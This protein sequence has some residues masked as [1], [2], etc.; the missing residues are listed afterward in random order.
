MSDVSTWLAHEW[1]DRLGPA[2][3]AMSGT[4]AQAKWDDAQPPLEGD[5]AL[6][7]RQ[8]VDFSP[9]TSI[10]VAFG[11]EVWFAI[12]KRVLES[13]GL[14][15]ADESDVRGTFIEVLQQSLS[16]LT[17]P[18]G[19][20]VEH[21]VSMSG[22]EASDALPDG[23]EWRAVEVSM[24]NGTLGRAWLAVTRPMEEALAIRERA[25]AAQVGASAEATALPRGSRTL[26]L[27]MEVELPVGVSFGRAQMRLKDAIKLTT[28]SIVEL[29]R[30]IVEPVEIVVN[31]CVIARGEV[32]VVQ[33]NYGVR[34]QQ[35]ISREERLRTLF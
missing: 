1:A 17:S 32:V 30:S 7:W 20:R 11:R 29:N 33:G 34:I 22:G 3:S 27:L 5:G 16:Q 24:D 6:L 26:D 21:E 19:A 31:N 14:E 9:E 28:G 15:D 8:G 23:L 12:G 35:I 10:W 25:A 13:A 2:V 18:M 4:A